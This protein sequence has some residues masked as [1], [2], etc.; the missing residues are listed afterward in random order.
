MY[1]SRSSPTPH[2]STRRNARNCGTDTATAV[3]DPA[4]RNLQV[5]AKKYHVAVCF[6]FI[7]RCED[8]LYS[9]QIF[10]GSNGEII[11][12]FHR[13][14]V[15]WKEFYKSDEHSREGERFAKFCYG[16]K[17]FAI[18]LCGD[19]WTDGRPEEMKN[20][21]TDVVLW[22]VWCDYAAEEW[23]NTIKHEYAEQA[24]LCGKCV[25]LVNPFC[26]DADAVDAAS[27]GAV[28]FENGKI[29]AELPAGTIGHMIVE[30]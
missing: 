17:S 29:V 1:S 24:A 20:L 16:G 13:V 19:L 9:S 14:S 25:L 30:L 4:I 3:S 22:P 8:A 18:G 12:L 10:I 28:H 6:G 15:G 11:N 27:G 26:A 5:A 21:D 2:I 7:E 23:N